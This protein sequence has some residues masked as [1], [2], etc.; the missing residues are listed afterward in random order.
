MKRINMAIERKMNY[1][2]R[3]EISSLL[4]YNLITKGIQIQNLMPS[5]NIYL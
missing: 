3:L 4:S 2:K 5:V 1:K